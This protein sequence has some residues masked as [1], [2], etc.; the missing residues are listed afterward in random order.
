MMTI[1]P[2]INRAAAFFLL[3]V[4]YALAYDNV[5]QQAAQAHHNH[6]TSHPNLKP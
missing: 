4:V 6:P 2:W 3:V 5:K 1:N